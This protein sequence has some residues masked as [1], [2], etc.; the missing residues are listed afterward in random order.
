MCECRCCIVGQSATGGIQIEPQVVEPEPVRC[1]NCDEV[2]ADCGCERCGACDLRIDD[3][4]ECNRCESCDLVVD[5]DC[6][7]LTCEN[8]G[9]RFSEE[10]E[11][12]CTSCRYCA[13]CI[14]RGRVDHGVCSECEECF[15]R[16]AH[17]HCEQCG[18]ADCCRDFNCPN[19]GEICGN[20]TNCCECESPETNPIKPYSSRQYPVSIP[21]E[22][23][24]PHNFLYI[25]TE[26]ETEAKTRE[27]LQSAA[28]YLHEHFGKKILM[29]EDGSLGE[30]GVELVTGKLSLEEQAKLWHALCYAAVEQG[31]RSWNYKSTGLHVHLSRAFFTQLALGKF[32]VFINSDHPVIR[33]HITQLAGRESA[34]YAHV[35]KKI[36]GRGCLQ[37]D[38][39]Y[40][41]VNLEPRYTVEVRIFKGT[42][43]AEHVLADIQFCH[44][45]AMWCSQ[46]SIADCESWNSFWA[47]VLRAENSKQYKQLI[48][49][50]NHRATTNTM[51]ER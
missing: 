9:V 21:A 5:H 37:S 11:D 22:H 47:F 12:C 7:C 27:R 26:N 4:C 51:E 33:K 1:Q 16:G 49:F 17:N 20:C 40:Q 35:Q 28:A 32:I 39:R 44:A 13:G 41:A 36:L 38:G 46:N 18:I 10:D 14:S 45:A 2:E 29:K 6:E 43:N 50:F 42:L 23:T 3:E 15:E 8:C 30:Y 31:L 48:T 19:E 34:S 25:G 24:V